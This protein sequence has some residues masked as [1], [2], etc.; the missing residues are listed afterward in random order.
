[1]SIKRTWRNFQSIV[2]CAGLDRGDIQVVAE[3]WETFVVGCGKHRT[4]VLRQNRVLENVKLSL[5]VLLALP[6]GLALHDIRTGQRR[7]QVHVL[8]FILS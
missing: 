1:M 6:S 5:L 2:L 8:R 4:Y 7:E 3:F